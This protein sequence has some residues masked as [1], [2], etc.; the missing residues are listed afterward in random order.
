M[1]SRQQRAEVRKL[2]GDLF[3][4]V[5][6]V[7]F[8]ADPIGINFGSNIDEYEPEVGTILPR[9][10]ECRSA[11]DVQTVV[12][13]EFVRWFDLGAD[14]EKASYQRYLESAENIWSIWQCYLAGHNSA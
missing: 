5:A 10:H 11:N 6:A 2:Y 14:D 3:D 13:E 7:L 4:E 9:L 1:D 12:H 8:A